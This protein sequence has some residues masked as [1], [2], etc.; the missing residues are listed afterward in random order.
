MEHYQAGV[1]AGENT[2]RLL[3]FPL[4]TPTGN[5]VILRVACCA[6]C[7]LEQRIYSGV[8][9]RYPFAGGHEVSGVVKAIGPGVKHIKPGEKAVIRLLN[10]CGECYYCRNGHENQC[11][12]S[13]QAS[14]H[15]GLNGPG[16]FAEYLTT[17]A[18]NVYKL[19]QEINLEHASLT[20][21]LACCVHSV[22]K[23]DIQMSE[24][25]VV[26]GA[27][28]MGVLHIQ[29]AKLRGARVIVCELDEARLDTARR[30]GAD[31]LICSS[32]E[33]AVREVLRLTENRGADA[34]FCTAALPKAAEDS[35]AM[36]GK[37]GRVILYSSFY[38]AESIPVNINKIHST[39]VVITGSVNPDICDFSTACRLLSYGLADVSGLITEIVPL[40]E[41]DRAFQTALL[42]SSY[43]VVVKCF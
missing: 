41:L 31:N 32:R 16:G 14:T 12:A 11:E 4:K 22:K 38:P 36:A 24:D 17:D 13:F 15:E 3:Q 1:I 43:R 42:P 20:E 33:D 35:V 26:I 18:K 34:V 40:Q 21:P 7:T 25:V 39:E 5:Q 37:L 6:V 28:T 2:V 9:K 8:M 19:P 29:L 27:G 30:M 10:A 23:A